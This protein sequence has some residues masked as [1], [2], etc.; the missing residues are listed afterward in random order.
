MPHALPL[1]DPTLLVR[2][3]IPDDEMKLLKSMTLAASFNGLALATETFTSPGAQL[4]IRG[5]PAAALSGER[6]RV[7][8]TLDKWSPPAKKTVERWVS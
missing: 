5:N 7:D 2:A 3:S 1:A 4:Y 8:F 6:A